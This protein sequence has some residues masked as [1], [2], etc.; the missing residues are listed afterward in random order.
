MTSSDGALSTTCVSCP[1]D[2][3]RSEPPAN[4]QDQI[5]FVVDDDRRICEALS[6]LLSAFD[7]H[8]DTF[9]SAAEYIAYPKPDVPACLTLE[10][11]C[12]TL[13]AWISKASLHR[14]TALKSYSSRD[15]AIF[16]RRYAR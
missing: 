3:D 12:P 6:E 13:T 10:V 5:V 11:S 8:V 1:N 15:T 2:G 9:G 4:Q 14:E 16:P 7:M